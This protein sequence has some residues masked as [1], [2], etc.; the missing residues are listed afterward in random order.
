MSCRVVSRLDEGAR[1]RSGLRLD[2]RSPHFLTPCWWSLR[3]FRFC[4]CLC[5][6]RPRG[7]VIAGTWHGFDARAQGAFL[8]VRAFQVPQC[9]ISRPPKMRDLRRPHSGALPPP[10]SVTSSTGV[11]GAGARHVSLPVLIGIFLH[12]VTD[13]LY[14][15]SENRSLSFFVLLRSEHGRNFFPLPG[16]RLSVSLVSCGG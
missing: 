10:N 2:W 9:A 15:R 14:S 7:F 5:G 4:R 1:R 3:R 12:C 6:R 8:R 11:G 13:A 16:T